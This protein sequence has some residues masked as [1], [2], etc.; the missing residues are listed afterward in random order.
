MSAVTR[1]TFDLSTTL[2]GATGKTHRRQL[3]Q[4]SLGARAC[5]SDCFSACRLFTLTWL[6][7]G[8]P[9]SPLR[10]P[11]LDMNGPDLVAIA[12]PY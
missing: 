1:D 4:E 2:V 10:A 9:G 11:A 5:S 3:G 7:P 12:S 6:E 8:T